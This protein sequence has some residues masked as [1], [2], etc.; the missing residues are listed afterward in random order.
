VLVAV[1]AADEAEA[2]PE[3]MVLM[4]ELTGSWWLL[5]EA[6]LLLALVLLVLLGLSGVAP[7]LSVCVLL[8]IML[9]LLLLLGSIMLLL[10]PVVLL[11]VLLRFCCWYWRQRSGLKAC[12]CCHA[13][14]D[15]CMMYGLTK[16]VVPVYAP[17]KVD[18][19][20][21]TSRFGLM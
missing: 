12:G 6:P 9:L 17:F 7:L 1:D 14:S 2:A 15:L 4:P 10:L 21:H 11:D 5:P 16:I 18:Y 19:T 13:C 8:L 3:P 20:H